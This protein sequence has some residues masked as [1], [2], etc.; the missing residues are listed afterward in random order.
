[1]AQCKQ[2]H[3]G[4]KEIRMLIQVN[5]TPRNMT[6]AGVYLLIYNDTEGKD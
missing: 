5:G 6:G 1:M 4:T 2:V 3:K